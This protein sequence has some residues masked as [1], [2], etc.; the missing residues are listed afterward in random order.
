MN[1]K[2]IR[3]LILLIIAGSILTGCAAGIR[4]E[5]TPGITVSDDS[6]Y[7]AY[8]TNLYQI[9]RTT[10]AKVSD[11]VEKE[12][13]NVVMYAPPLVDDGYVYYGDLA[14][15]FHKVS[16]DNL[17]GS[18]WTFDGAKGWYQGKAAIVGDLIIAPSTDRDI[19]ALNKDTGEK[20][21]NFAGEFAF[22]SE[23]VVVG[24]KIIV[25]AQDHH[26]LV[27][28]SKTG[29]EIYR[30][31]MVGAVLSSPLYD[32]ESGS[33]FV[34]SLAPEV[35]SF[36]L[37]TGDVN[38]TYGE[39][40]E[41]GSIWGTPILNGD[42]LIFVDKSGMIIALDKNTGEDL[43]Q[44]NAGGE[45]IAGAVLIEGE[46]FLVAREDGIINFYSAD[47]HAPVWTITVPGNIYSK[48]IID[49]DQIF[50]PVINGDALLYTY[51]TTSVPGWFFKAG[52]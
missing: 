42:E 46:G 26:V 48:P 36:N 20:V 10:G 38:W 16:A 7:L 25:S 28:N 1:K 15:K 44:N 30:V 18:S 32:P 47:N 5:S 4:A 50:V 27:L 12:S 31:E 51:S 52:N 34:G 11:A 39:G 6:V 14:N 3:L 21:W 37:E 9:D 23:P 45:V 35:I 2:A 22:I 17:R 29:E 41:L 24:D 13:A 49:G 33:V 43:W 40:K 19:Y 8:L